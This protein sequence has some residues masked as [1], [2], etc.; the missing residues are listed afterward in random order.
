ML[1]VI[2]SCN[3]HVFSCNVFQIILDVLNNVLAPLASRSSSKFEADQ[4]RTRL[5]V[6]FVFCC[7]APLQG[8]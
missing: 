5:L 3:D 6:R 2:L 8:R 4:K 1:G 7:K